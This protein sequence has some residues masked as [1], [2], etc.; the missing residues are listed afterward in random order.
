MEKD[1]VLEFVRNIAILTSILFIVLGL[2]NL[3][4]QK[5][6]SKCEV[7]NTDFDCYS[8]Y[9]K[10]LVGQKGVSK[11]FEALK[12]EFKT[13]SYV[14]SQCHPITHVIGHAAVSLYPEISEA[15]KHGDPYCWSGYY[16]GVMEEVVEKV[17]INKISNKL[18][19]ICSLVEGKSE[20]SF[21]YYNCVHGLGHGL[22][23]INNDELFNSLKMCD[24]L[25][26]SWERESC[27]G[28]VYMENVIIDNRGDYTKYLKPEDPLYPC[29]AVEYKYKSSCY[30]MQSS[31]ALKVFKYDFSKVF[32]I[33]RKAD[34]GFTAICF[35][36][37]GRDASGST[38]SNAVP[39]KDKCYLGK[40]YYEQSNCVT[41]AVKDFISYYHSDV[42][43]KKFCSILTPDLKKHCLKIAEDYYKTF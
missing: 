27:Y 1:K 36:S 9:Y 22:M 29:N 14:V 6:I 13:N 17:G 34:D 32:D 4:A 25:S 41:G 5:N 24:N 31:Y 12:E 3:S 21:D 38:S 10:S 39:T 19:T 7:G 18:D 2:S 33:C 40:D 26:G 42:Q 28:G 20:Y 23:S 43:A 35:Q 11:A 8:E 15:F 16:H 30:L 37:V